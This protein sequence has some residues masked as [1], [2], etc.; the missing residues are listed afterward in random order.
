M[1]FIETFRQPIT[2][3][4]IG[5]ASVVLGIFHEVIAIKNLHIHHRI[6]PR[7]T[8][9]ER[10]IGKK[11]SYNSFVS[12]SKV[13]VEGAIPRHKSGGYVPC[14]IVCAV[15]VQGKCCQTSD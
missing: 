6:A 1:V 3:Y 2:T 5:V 10:R 8:Y 13:E 4:N 7:T 9:L 11:F 14:T 12:M 15:V